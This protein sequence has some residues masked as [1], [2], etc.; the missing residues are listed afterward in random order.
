MRYVAV[1]DINDK[2]RVT[3]YNLERDV[4]VLEQ[5]SGG[6]EMKNLAW[7][8]RP[9]DLRLAIQSERQLQFWNP[10]DVTKKL[11]NVGTFDKAK[12]TNFHCVTFDEEGW[13]YTGGDNGEV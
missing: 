13:C 9:D 6:N 7:S 1:V 5:E 3:I 8:R 12:Q 10:A 2:H 4:K 11:K